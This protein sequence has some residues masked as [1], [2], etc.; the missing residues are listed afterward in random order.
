MTGAAQ[1]S[2]SDY[3]II[4]NTRSAALISRDATIEWLCWPRF[5]SASWFAALLDPE[6]GGHFSLHP[7]GAFQATRRYVGETNVLETTFRTAKGELRLTD[8]MPVASEDAKRRE[9]WP[10]H[11]ILRRMECVE[12][13]V[14]MELT[15]SPRPDYAR[16]AAG[17]R[18]R[19]RLGIFCDNEDEVL[20]LRAEVPLAISIGGRDARGSFT[21]RKGERRYVSL[22]FSKR[23][24]AVL[25]PLDTTADARLDA[26]LAWWRQWIERCQYEGPFRDTVVRSA[27]TLKLMTYAPSGA[28]IAAPTTS[29]PEHPGGVRNWDYRYC[30]LRDSSLT[31]Q[32]LLDLGYTAEA[33]SFLSWTIHTTRITWPELQ[34]VYNVYGGAE[35]TEEELTHLAGFASSRPVRVGNGAAGQL[36]LDVYGEVLDAVYQ[37]VRRGGRLDRLTKRMIVGFGNTVCKRWREPDEGIWEIRAGRRHHTYSKAMGWVALDRLLKLH[38]AEQLEVPVEQFSRERAAIRDQIEQRG[39]NERI[40]SY[41]SVLDGDDVDASLLMLA[42]YGSVD[43]SSPRMRSTL[44][45]IQQ[46]LGANGLLYRYRRTDD[47]ISGDEGAFGICSFWAVSAQALVGDR[48]GAATAFER[49]LPFANDVGLFAEEIDPAT[50]AAL[51]NFPQAFTHVGVIDAALVLAAAARGDGT[52]PATAGGGHV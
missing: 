2:I 26:S 4:G 17:L 18:D 39:Y 37:Y 32:A 47:G 28:V 36:Q 51:G 9:L 21:L 1:R 27:L 3:A 41:V 23:E 50:G 19:G 12:G 11:E 43:P 44:A 14:S 30:W 10:E 29:L 24:P 35:L 7:S 48:D 38:E 42:R 52:E 6:R 13:E 49:V 8:L 15:Y 45:V 25:P 46:R 20:V 16:A 40:G 31:L 22:V 33:E 5:D 34:V